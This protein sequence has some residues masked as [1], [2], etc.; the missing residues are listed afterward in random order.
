M[1]Y[2]RNHKIG[3]G[4]SKYDHNPEAFDIDI[5]TSKDIHNQFL[6]DLLELMDR[7]Y[8]IEKQTSYGRYLTADEK[9]DII[10]EYLYKVKTKG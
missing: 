8:Y 4:S 10:V 2:F 1:G 5:Q 9:M 6:K 7:K 3:N